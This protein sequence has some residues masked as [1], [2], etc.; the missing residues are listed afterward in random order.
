VAYLALWSIGLVV[1]AML[2]WNWRRR[3]GPVTFVERQVA[4]AWAAGVIASSGTFL[5][6][7]LLGQPA[8]ILTPILAVLSGMVF[9]FKAGTLTGWFYVAAALCFLAAV[10]MALCR[11]VAP[12][13]LGIVSGIGFLVPGL[14]Y[15]RRRH[16]PNTES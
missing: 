6:E 5:V 13:L 14:R 12:L 16:N 3:A 8:L 2:F 4:H 15:Y 9:L 7:W 1:W 11:D 10:P